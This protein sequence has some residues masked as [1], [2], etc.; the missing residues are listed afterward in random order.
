MKNEKYEFRKIGLSF[1]DETLCHESL[2]VVKGKVVLPHIQICH[3]D[4][5]GEFFN[6]IL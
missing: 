5:V 1:K 3:S 2:E 6:V 4:S